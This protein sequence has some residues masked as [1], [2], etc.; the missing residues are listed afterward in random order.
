[1]K[2]INDKERT[3]AYFQFL[4]L[5]I[6]FLVLW[7]VAVFFD[8]R[9]KAKD[10]QVLKE[11][12]KKLKET[13]AISTD[14]PHQIDS[15]ASRVKD[16]KKVTEPDFDMARKVLMDDINELWLDDKQDTAASARI[17]KA[18]ANIFKQWTYD[19]ESSF[20]ISDVA[21]K[22]KAKEDELKEL[23]EKYKTCK[24]E[25]TDYKRIYY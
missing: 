4:V 8:Y 19:V 23:E 1:M 25:F 24:E 14:L 17:R 10:Y 13:L 2:P 16:L 12:N 3:L 6:L 11:E 7:T 5:S 20:R 22:L 15:F 18:T 21:A 9:V